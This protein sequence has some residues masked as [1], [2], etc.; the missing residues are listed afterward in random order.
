MDKS[1]NCLLFDL[2][3]NDIDFYLTSHYP[4][5]YSQV[6]TFINTLRQYDFI[7]VMKLTTT[8]CF[9]QVPFVEIK[10]NTNCSK[11]LVLTARSHASD[12]GSSYALQGFLEFILGRKNAEYEAQLAQITDKV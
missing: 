2:I 11:I 5:P 1:A 7:R 4:Y 8:D 12:T 6:I 10:R 3:S 9:N